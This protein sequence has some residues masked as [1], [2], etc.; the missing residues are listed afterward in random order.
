MSYNDL[1]LA[2]MS[3]NEL[4]WPTMTYNE[5]QWPTTGNASIERNGNIPHED[6]DDGTVVDGD[7]KKIQ[8]VNE[9]Y[10]WI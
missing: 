5:L 10:D 9:S 3:Y 8:S 7:R 6:S 2:T 4:Q 1:Q